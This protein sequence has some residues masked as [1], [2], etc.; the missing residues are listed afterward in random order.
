MKVDGKHSQ[1]VGQRMYSALELF[2]VD[3][4]Q[5]LQEFCEPRQNGQA[6]D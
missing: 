3:T 5:P 6:A 2:I 1:P 4:E